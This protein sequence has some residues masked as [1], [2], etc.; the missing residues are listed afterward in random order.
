MSNRQLGTYELEQVRLPRDGTP[1]DAIEFFTAQESSRL[2]TLI[3]N[4]QL[5]GFIARNDDEHGPIDYQGW[6]WRSVDFFTPRGITIA[7]GDGRVAV[8]QSNKWGY[9]H[10]DLTEDEQAHFLSLIWAAHQESRKGGLLSEIHA[11]TNRLLAEANDYI[12][13]LE[14]KES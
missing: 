14:I 3:V 1:D 11:T 7:K 8:C 6:F 12:L 10:R 2:A 4:D 13:S 9:P 5:N